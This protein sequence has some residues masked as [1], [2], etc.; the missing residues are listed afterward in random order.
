MTSS[1]TEPLYEKSICLDFWNLVGVGSWNSRRWTMNLALE[2]MT[3][4]F[5]AWLE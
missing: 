1:H 2:Q 5:V 4:G 3:L